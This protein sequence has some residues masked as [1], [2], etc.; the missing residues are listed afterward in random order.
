VSCYHDTEVVIVDAVV[1][2]R[3]LKQMR[4]LLK[5]RGRDEGL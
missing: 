5:P 1:V 3:G 4:V 2:D